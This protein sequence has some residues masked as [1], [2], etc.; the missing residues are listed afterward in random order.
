MCNL[1]ET[2]KK[3]FVSDKNFVIFLS[4]TNFVT[5]FD[6]FEHV[7]FLFFVTKFRT[8]WLLYDIFIFIPEELAERTH[9]SFNMV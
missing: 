9:I 3:H 6:R 7:L 5:K 4:E 1:S 8:K 2:K